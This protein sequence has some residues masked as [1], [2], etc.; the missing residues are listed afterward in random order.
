M[1]AGL[2]IHNVLRDVKLLRNAHYEAPRT[3]QHDKP[4]LCGDQL[5]RVACARN[6]GR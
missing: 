1:L 3:L 4:S 6:H 2:G 5:Q